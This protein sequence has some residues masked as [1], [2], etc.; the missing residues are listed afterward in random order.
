M[1]G[2]SE[3]LNSVGS[4]L[5]QMSDTAAARLLSEQN[6]I[7]SNDSLSPQE[8][9]Y[10]LY[11]LLLRYDQRSET[12]IP[13]TPNATATTSNT[14][15]GAIQP[16]GGPFPDRSSKVIEEQPGV[17]HSYQEPVEAQSNI[18]TEDKI[19]AEEMQ[20]S[21]K[22]SGTVPGVFGSVVHDDSEVLHAGQ[23]EKEEINVPVAGA[24]QSRADITAGNINGSGESEAYNNVGTG[25]AY[26]QSTGSIGDGG[27][28][29]AA[30]VGTAPEP[31][32]KS[33][34]VYWPNILYPIL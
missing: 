30:S 23:D 20:A 17:D 29:E 34:L 31:D 19:R 18:I 21:A 7:F 32:C 28:S 24:E 27:V 6:L 33:Y 5:R 26:T 13:E 12:S 4:T 14:A 3:S 1:L 10:Q 2:Q 11:M 22:A 16:F 8:R 9:I 25:D 15:G